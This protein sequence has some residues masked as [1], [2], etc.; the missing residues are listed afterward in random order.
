LRQPRELFF[1]MQL[2]QLER[3]PPK[4]IEN[5]L[6]NK[7]KI[8]GMEDDLNFKAVQDDLKKE[9]KNGRRPQFLF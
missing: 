9:I 8:D 3:R 5:N 2:T 4:K 7:I 1:G 6:K